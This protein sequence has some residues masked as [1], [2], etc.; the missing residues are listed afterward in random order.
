MVYNINFLGY[1]PICALYSFICDAKIRSPLGTDPL[2]A[3]GIEVCSSVFG[4]L[5]FVS[6]NGFFMVSQSYF[7]LSPPD[8]WRGY[9]KIIPASVQ[10]RLVLQR[11]YPVL[12]FLWT[13]RDGWL[14]SAPYI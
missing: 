11:I 7:S 12:V 9:S 8:N 13:L 1:L 2:T 6:S 4:Y 10:N 5:A 3:I 14:S